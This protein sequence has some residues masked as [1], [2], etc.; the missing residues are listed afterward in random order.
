MG[1][2]LLVL[3]ILGNLMDFFSTFIAVRYCGLVEGNPKVRSLITK[4]G[5]WWTWWIMKNLCNLVLMAGYLLVISTPRIFDISNLSEIEM[6]FLNLCLR[7]IDIMMM[8][9][10]FYL[11]LISILNVFNIL[12]KIL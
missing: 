11:W 3:C 9:L 2:R 4:S 7:A 6:K 8:G 12:A 1:L 5:G 10:T